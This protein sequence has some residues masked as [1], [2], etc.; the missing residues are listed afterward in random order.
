[1]KTPPRLRPF[2]VCAALVG[3]PLPAADFAP[4]DAAEFA[5]CLP[6]DAKVERLA[7]G[8]GFTEGPVWLPREGIL[9]FSDIPK[10]QLLRW[11]PGGGIAGFREPSRNANGNTLDL[12]GRLLTCEHSG[13]R[14]ARRE[15]DGTLVTVVD[16]FEGRRLN[17]PNDIVVKADGTL[18]FTDPEYGLKTNPATKQREGKEQPGNFVYRHDP[19]TGTT[20]AV[21]RDFV[22]PNGLAFSPDEKLLYVADS[23]APRHIRVFAVGADGRLDA[24][25]VFCQ[26]DKGGP[27]GIRVDREG[28]VWSSSGDGVQIFQPD[29]RLIGRILLPESAANLCFGGPDGK[30]L[31]ITARKS[32][33]A[34][35]T[36]VTGAGR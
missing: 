8:L 10:D 20:T 33:Y 18:W 2:L 5:R 21:V 11:S 27:D 22:Q 36:S 16:R 32:L 13:R 28:R 30:T 3:L 29:G 24:G 17:S 1:M 31:Y 23:G 12:Q 6:A 26:L 4:V 9:V 14:V 35:R 7:T 15:A 25:R 19:A 34:V